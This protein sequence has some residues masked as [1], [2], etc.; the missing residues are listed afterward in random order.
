M[1]LVA[2][3]PASSDE[4]SD[5]VSTAARLAGAPQQRFTLTCISKAARMECGGACRARSAG[6]RRVACIEAPGEGHDL[7]RPVT[8]FYFGV[9]LIE[10][11][12]RCLDPE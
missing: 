1:S 2:E 3:V 12:T 10:F 6:W 5:C 11:L 7:A 9:A 8:Q 4:E